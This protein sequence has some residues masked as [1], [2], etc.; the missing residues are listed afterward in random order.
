M[1]TM[2]KQQGLHL[3]RP[4]VYSTNKMC[5]DRASTA[6][7]CAAGCVQQHGCAK[8]RA[9]LCCVHGA[10]PL[11][12]ASRAAHQLR[13]DCAEDAHQGGCHICAEQMRTYLATSASGLDHINAG[14]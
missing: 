3:H 9:W 14:Q 7:P 4:L 2:S 11:L 8:N 6:A 10:L 5:G 1:Q 13:K 12:M